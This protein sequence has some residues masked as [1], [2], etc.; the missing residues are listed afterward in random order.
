MWTGART[1]EELEQLLEDVF[2]LHDHEAL[3]QLFEPR[4]VLCTGAIASQ[5]RGSEAIA[6]VAN[7]LWDRNHRY[8]ADPRRILQ[9]RSTALVLSQQ[10]INVLGRDDSGTWRFAICCLDEVAVRGFHNSSPS[11]GD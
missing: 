3:L 1:P 9:A 7:L 5:A 11:T 4:A 2:V 8:L 10:A 6:Q